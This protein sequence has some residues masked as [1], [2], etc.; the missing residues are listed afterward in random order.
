MTPIEGKKEILLQELE[1]GLEA[2][3]DPNLRASGKPQF[4]NYMHSSPQLKRRY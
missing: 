1:I 3:A 2:E 4:T